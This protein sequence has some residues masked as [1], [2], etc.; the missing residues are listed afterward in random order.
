MSGRGLT[1]LFALFEFL[2]QLSY[3]FPKLANLLFDPLM[4]FGISAVVLEAHRVR[5]N[6]VELAVLALPELGILLLRTAVVRRVAVSA[7][8][9]VKA[10]AAAVRNGNL[11]FLIVTHNGEFRS[12][13]RLH[14]LDQHD[15]IMAP[16]D[17][18][19]VDGNDRIAWMQP[20][21]GGRS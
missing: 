11:R 21:A 7:L 16:L 9:A 3:L 1:H 8:E 4:L 10:V 17:F 12:R 14:F 5:R 13:T 2:A 6:I 15:Q 19:A 20:R 18:L